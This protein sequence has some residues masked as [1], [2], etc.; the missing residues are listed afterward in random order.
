MF[1]IH[2]SIDINMKKGESRW[3]KGVVKLWT[4]AIIKELKAL[5]DHMD[6]Q[7]MQDLREAVTE[8]AKRKAKKE[9]MR[10]AKEEEM[11]EAKEAVMKEAK[12][13]VMKEA[14]KE[15]M[16]EVKKEAMKEAKKEAISMA[17]KMLKSGKFTAEEILEYIPWLS[18]E[19]IL[20]IVSNLQAGPQTKRNGWGG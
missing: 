5:S 11:K 9:A 1:P 7:S 19:E 2:I 18:A 16:K 17:T 15:A 12:K 14:K 6:K 10:E 4:F 8:E 3:Q 20:H 13:A